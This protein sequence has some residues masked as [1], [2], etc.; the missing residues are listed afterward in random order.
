M[1]GDYM[2]KPLQGA[3]FMKFEDKNMGV[4]PDTYTGPV[5]VKVE[6]L[7]KA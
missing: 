4:I 6:Q 7:R 1:I 2:T 5:K 3:M